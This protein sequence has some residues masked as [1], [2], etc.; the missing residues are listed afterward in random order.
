MTTALQA[1]ENNNSPLSFGMN[2]HISAITLLITDNNRSYNDGVLT[3]SI[4]ELETN[5]VINN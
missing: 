4:T 5:Y 2:L 1:M 3:H